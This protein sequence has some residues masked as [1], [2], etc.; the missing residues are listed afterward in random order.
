LVANAGG[1]RPSGNF[2]KGLGANVTSMKEINSFENVGIFT[3][4]SSAQA[5]DFFSGS[6][7]SE[8]RKHGT[9]C[10]GSA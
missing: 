6:L 4:V 2:I 7:S 9:F 5:M 3:L 1:L 8:L 10:A